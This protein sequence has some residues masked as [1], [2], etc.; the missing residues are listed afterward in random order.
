MTARHTTACGLGLALLLSVSGAAPVRASAPHAES[1]HEGADAA[2]GHG[3]HEQ[4][5]NWFHGVFVG[6]GEASL[7]WRPPGT[8]PPF[9]ALLLN[10]ALLAFLLVRFGRKP[11]VEGLAARRKAL[12]RSADEAAEMEAEA[13]QQ[14]AFYEEKL[15][16]LDAEINRV[17][18]EMRAAAEA[19]RK[20]VLQE[21]AARRE[22][23]EKE[24]QTLLAQEIRAAQEALEKSTKRAALLSARRILQEE[25]TSHDDRRLCDVYLDRGV[26][27]NL[28]QSVS[29]SSVSR[30]VGAAGLGP[31]DEDAGAVGGRVA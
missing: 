30:A 14:L 15:S 18:G 28:R 19:E 2:A 9:A 7:L 29:P 1:A 5:F 8:P 23:I 12:S 22:R 26:F 3:E 10:T 11:V 16:N 27:G 21:A 6:D 25:I 31:A 20:R 17:K 4:P 13:R 24:A